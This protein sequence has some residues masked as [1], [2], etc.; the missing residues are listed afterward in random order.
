MSG[1]VVKKGPA[2]YLAMAQ[3]DQSSL[4]DCLRQCWEFAE[5]GSEDEQQYNDLLQMA[6]AVEGALG[7]A[8]LLL[9][10]GDA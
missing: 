2:D 8:A 9:G 10:G 4:V 6:E 7:A 3:R 5:E 1:A